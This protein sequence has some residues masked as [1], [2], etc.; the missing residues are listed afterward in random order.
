MSDYEHEAAKPAVPHCKGAALSLRFNGDYLMLS[1]KKT[2]I[3]PAVSGKPDKAGHFSNT[4]ERQKQKGIGLTPRGNAGSI[5]R[6]CGRTPDTS[7]GHTPGGA[8]S[9]SQSTSSPPPRRMAA[10]ASSFMGAP[11]L[12]APAAST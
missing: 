10:V 6:S 3:F 9:A 5:S 1:G 8:T 2:Y 11:F 7:A 4:V 12:G